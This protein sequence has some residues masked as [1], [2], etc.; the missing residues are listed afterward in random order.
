MKKRTHKWINGTKGA[1]SL[2]LAMLLLPFYS[3]AAMLVEAGRYQSAVKTLD[4]ALGSSAISTLA[5]FDTYLKDRFGLL[6]ISQDGDLTSTMSGYLNGMELTD[7]SSVDLTGVSAEG[8]YPLADT[9]VLRRQV[10]EY[11]KV[12][13]PAKVVTD[14]IGIDELVKKLEKATKMVP[15]LNTISSG[16]DAVSAEADALSA[17]EDAKDAAEDVQA[18]VSEYNSTFS[19][20]QSAVTALA[21]H[22]ATTRPSDEKE[23]KNWDKTRDDLR[24]TAEDARKDYEDAIGDLISDID[25]LQSKADGAISAASKFSNSLNN[26]AITAT[27]SGQ[28]LAANTS[29]LSKEEKTEVE[30]TVKTNSAIYSAINSGSSDINNSIQDCI[31]SFDNEKMV[32]A[33]RELQADKA[34][35]AAFDTDAVT[36]TTQVTATSY[37]TADVSNL[38]DADALNEILD[39]SVDEVNKGGLFDFVS[40]MLAVLNSMFRTKTVFDPS[41]NS[42]LDTEYYNSAIGGLPSEKDRG[43]AANTLPTGNA[44]DEERSK[45]YLE[46]I[47]PDYDPDDPYGTGSDFNTSRID[48]IMRDINRM[49]NAADDVKD[50]FGKISKLKE[51]LEA[52]VDLLDA[53]MDLIA[54]TIAFLTEIVARVLQL[55]GEAAYER[56]L[57]NGYLA[58]NLPNRTTYKTGSTL[59]NYSFSKIAYGEIPA[60]ELFQIPGSGSSLMAMVAAISGGGGFTNKSFSGAE[61]EYILWG[62]NSEIANQSMQF[63]ALYLVRLLLD[64]P[65]LM[66][67]QE[68]QS[69]ISLAGPLAPLVAVIYIFGEPYADTLILVNGGTVNLIKTKPYLTIEGLPDLVGEFTSLPMTDDMSNTIKSEASKMTGLT[70]YETAKKE[71]GNKGSSSILDDIL[72][73]NYTEY[74][75]LMMMIFGSEE[76]YLRRLTTII[77]TE[78]TAYREENRSLSQTAAGTSKSFNIDESYTVIRAQAEGSLVQVLPVPSLSTS[79]VFRVDRVIYRGY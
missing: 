45:E 69:Y 39:A 25:T 12:L 44:E 72:A 54:D 65:V 41:L 29:G 28:Q 53:I 48:D 26:F 57:V 13:V 30:N 60:E 35:V 70:I 24:K 73:L 76:T 2:L 8:M 43:Q 36:G 5:N 68:V 19:A 21:S 56:L 18:S 40:S 38:A 59:A 67:N 63:M 31:N 15:L 77:Q 10:L 55:L 62:F 22:M 78:S 27:D 64:L 75:L 71:D 20:W 6:A 1:I 7:M 79:S 74:S 4:G 49:M 16:C 47:D 23:A 42:R 66:S 50:N 9:T 17:L 33:S 34:A 51:F 52:I 46:A 3:L 61:L 14:G 32:Q 58:Y 37:H 11:S